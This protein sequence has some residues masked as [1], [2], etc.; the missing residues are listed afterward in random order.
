MQSHLSVVRA[1]TNNV[2]SEVPYR[3]LLDGVEFRVQPFEYFSKM[4]GQ[5]DKE[6]V[7]GTNS[8]EMAL[9]KLTLAGQRMTREMFLVSYYLFFTYS[10]LIGWLIC[11]VFSFQCCYTCIFVKKCVDG[12]KKKCA[13]PFQLLQHNSSYVSYRLFC[14][15]MHIS[16]YKN[17]TSIERDK[18]AH[19]ILLNYALNKALTKKSSS[20]DYT[21]YMKRFVFFIKSFCSLFR[22]KA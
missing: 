22:M 17:V 2:D 12:I 7:L 16:F 3:P 18:F 9:I 14:F 6:I 5:I 15:L 10:E 4:E 11:T 19:S 21:S 20:D 8:D 13:K 1:Q